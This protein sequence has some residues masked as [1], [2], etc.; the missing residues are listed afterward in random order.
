MAV[1]EIRRETCD[2]CEVVLETRVSAV[3]RGPHRR[4]PRRDVKRKTRTFWFGMGFSGGY[5]GEV[6]E[7]ITICDRDSCYVKGLAIVQ[8]KVISRFNARLR[9]KAKKEKV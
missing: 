8:E 1:E 2:V 4:R 5:G 6:A 7:E 9:S 3:R